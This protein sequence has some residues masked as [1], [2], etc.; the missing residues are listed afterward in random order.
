MMGPVGGSA[1]QVDNAVS[2]INA[3]SDPKAAKKRL[4]EIHAAM[5][6]AEKAEKA[7]SD[8]ETKAIKAKAEL[9]S[10]KARIAASLA[11]LE[12]RRSE[13]EKMSDEAK[14]LMAQAEIAFKSLDTEK[15]QFAKDKQDLVARENGLRQ[16]S[17]ELQHERHRL[18]RLADSIKQDQAEIDRKKAILA[19]L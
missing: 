2:L 16:R 19:Q 9:E 17:S 1:S 5:V 4:A 6:K 15:Y 13:V 11:E 7:A 3:L 12:R 18:K 10:E 8:A 14:H